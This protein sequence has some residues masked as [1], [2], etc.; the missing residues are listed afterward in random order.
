[1]LPAL[2]VVLI[3][4]AMLE[5]DGYCAILALTVFA[6]TICYFTVLGFGSAEGLKLIKNWLGGA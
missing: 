5:R 3:A 6:I 1:M 4:A 2:T